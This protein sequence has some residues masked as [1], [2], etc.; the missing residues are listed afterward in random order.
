MSSACYIVIG[1]KEVLP[2][3]TSVIACKTLEDEIN[4]ALVKTETN[5]PIYWIESGLHNYPD[6]LKHKIQQSID[7]ITNSDYILLLFGLCG[8]S[9]LGL[10]SAN[11]SLVIP[12]VDDCISL[13]LGGNEARRNREGKFKA[14]YLTKGWLRYEN[15]IWQE[16]NRSIERYGLEKTRSIFK[17]MLQHYTHLVVIDTGAYETIGFLKE[18]KTIADELGLTHLVVPGNLELLYRALKK[19]WDNNFAVIKPKN[20]ITLPDMGTCSNYIEIKND[21]GISQTG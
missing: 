11:A 16:Y 10:S 4:Q 18:T 19:K 21:S 7:R 1:K 9:M 2:I 13:F 14:Y 3:K 6:Q 5:F 20:K 8:N 15:N 17:I 12:K